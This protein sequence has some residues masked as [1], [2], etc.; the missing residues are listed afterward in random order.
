MALQIRNPP[1]RSSWSRGVDTKVQ[2]SLFNRIWF[3]HQGMRRE[4]FAPSG[5]SLKASYMGATVAEE[6]R[7]ESH[8]TPCL[9]GLKACHSVLV[10][11]KCWSPCAFMHKG[12]KCACGEL[13]LKK[14]LEGLQVVQEMPQ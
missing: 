13:N 14:Q 2:K 12:L 9:L 10:L 8:I 6:G 11:V 5:K 7:E 4:W 3:Y 1:L